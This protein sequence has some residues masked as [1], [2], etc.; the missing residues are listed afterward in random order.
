[1]SKNRLVITTAML[2]ALF[3][4]AVCSADE[5][6]G[7]LR[8]A[9]ASALSTQQAAN[10]AGEDAAQLAHRFYTNDVVIIGEGETKPSRGMDAAVKAMVD[11]N[12]YLGPGGQKKC[13]FELEDPVVGSDSTVSTFV[14]LSCKANPPKLTK[15]ETIRQLFVWKKTSEGWKV[16]M[17][18]WQS[19]GFG[20]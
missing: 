10:A 1:M 6:T 8:S 11:W 17:E 12:D 9:I 16:A 18:M 7:S 19:G 5:S 14:V 20:K 15:D 2:C 4:S 13:H 3:A